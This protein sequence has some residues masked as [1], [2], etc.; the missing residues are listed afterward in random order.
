VLAG[1][2][3]WELRAAQPLLDPRLFRHGGFAAGTL[4]VTLQFFAFFGFI[5]LLLQYLQLAL[6]DSPLEA[7]LSLVPRALP[8]MPFARVIAPRLAGRLGTALTLA[9]G[10]VVAAGASAWLSTLDAT[11][12]YW[13]LLA[14][15]L[16][17]GVGMGLAMTPTTAAIT[18]T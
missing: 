11:S 4:T 7:A 17:L 1:F 10:L 8:M 9:I 13:P 14:G 12:S 15:L 16:P 2:V 6:R 3:G 18:D 5:F